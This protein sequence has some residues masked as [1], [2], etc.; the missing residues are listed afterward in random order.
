MTG[1][2]SS[3]LF[4]MPPDGGSDHLRSKYFCSPV[5]TSSLFWL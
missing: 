3:A 5:S 1:K 4:G 2:V